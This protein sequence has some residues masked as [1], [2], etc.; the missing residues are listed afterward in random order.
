MAVPVTCAVSAGPTIAFSVEAGSAGGPIALLIADMGVVVPGL[1]TSSAVVVEVLA[2]FLR[3]LSSASANP[4]AWPAREMTSLAF[5]AAVPVVFWASIGVADV[6]APAAPST[7]RASSPRAVRPAPCSNLV[8]GPSLA[9]EVS[10]PRLKATPVR[11][12]GPHPNTLG[13]SWATARWGGLFAGF[14]VPS[15][16][17]RGTSPY[18]AGAWKP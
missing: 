6:H 7:R 11:A 12:R 9:V 3:V 1:T 4:S 15:R 5:A 17:W 13:R 18:L 2:A 10:G 16:A 8:I 14:L